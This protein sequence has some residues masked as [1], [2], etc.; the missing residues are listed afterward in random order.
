MF[1]RPLLREK[2]SRD[3]EIDSRIGPRQSREAKLPMDLTPAQRQTL[4]GRAHALDPVVLIGGLG[5][6]P[7]VLAEVDRALDSHELIKIRVTGADR[8]ARERL[9]GEIC[10]KTGAAPVQHIG[11]VALIYRPGADPRIRLPGGQRPD[12]A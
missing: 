2:P 7:A 11:K 5:L 8:S 10:G 9:L 4:K 3:F 1:V 12:D 6:T